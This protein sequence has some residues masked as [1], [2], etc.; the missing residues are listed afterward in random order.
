MKL[1]VY[2]IILVGWVFVSNAYAQKRNALKI[3]PLTFDNMMATQNYGSLDLMAFS[4]KFGGAIK[5]ERFVG[6]QIS[7]GLW[8]GKYYGTTSTYYSAPGSYS[9]KDFP[10]YEIN[11]GEYSLSGILFGYESI[12]FFEPSTKDGLNS[13]YFG[14]YYQRGNFTQGMEATYNNIST[15]DQEKIT[16]NQQ[17]L[18]VNRVGIKVGKSVTGSGAADYYFSLGYNF[19][20]G[21]TTTNFTAPTRV[22]PISLGF[23]V[24]LGLPF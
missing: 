14:V 1:K 24:L 15:Y 3:S 20:T 19:T 21:S 23:G 9:P 22:R 17:N 10:G 5:Y 16:F 12:L 4:Y 2:I 7:I 6:N 11:D 8:A 13:S 18:S